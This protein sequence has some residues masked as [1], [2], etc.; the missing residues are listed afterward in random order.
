MRALLY[1]IDEPEY[2]VEWQRRKDGIDIYANTK[3][4]N[5]MLCTAFD[6]KPEEAN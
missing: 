2:P 3:P 5:R 4:E 1:N 6:L